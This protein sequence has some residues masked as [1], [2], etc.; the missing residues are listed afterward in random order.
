MNEDLCFFDNT[1]EQPPTTRVYKV[2]RENFSPLFYG[3]NE[4]FVYDNEAINEFRSR[5]NGIGEKNVR[6]MRGLFGISLRHDMGYESADTLPPTTT[7]SSSRTMTTNKDASGK[8]ASQESLARAERCVR[9]HYPATTG[10]TLSCSAT[11]FKSLDSKPSK[12]D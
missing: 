12:P 6:R 2:L 8:Y 4:F 5:V 11:A 10:T 1:A 7:T 9:R 3:R